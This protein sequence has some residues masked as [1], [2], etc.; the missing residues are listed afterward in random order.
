MAISGFRFASALTLSLVFLFETGLEAKVCVQIRETPNCLTEVDELIGKTEEEVRLGDKIPL[1]LIHGWNSN[2]IPAPPQTEIW[3]NLINDFL[4]D[5]LINAKVKLYIFEYYSNSGT[6]IELGRAFRDLI[7]IQSGKDPLGFGARPILIVAHSL[8]G[9]IA[10]YFLRL[11]QSEGVFENS[12]GGDRTVLLI[13]LGTPHHGTMLANGESLRAKVSE[14]W[15]STLRL[16]YAL[17]CFAYCPDWFQPNRSDLR[18]DNFDGALDY[19][20]Y[21]GERN[22]FL[23]SLNKDVDFDEKMILYGGAIGCGGREEYPEVYCAGS[24]VI[25]GVF[26]QSSDGMAPLSSAFHDGTDAVFYPEKRFTR[27]Y[28]SEYDHNQIATG[29]GDGVLFQQIKED[30]LWVLRFISREPPTGLR[31]VVGASTVSLAWNSRNPGYTISYILEI[32]SGTGRTDVLRIPVDMGYDEN[33]LVRIKNIAPGRYFARAREVLGNWAGIASNEIAFTVKGRRPKAT[34][35]CSYS[36]L[37]PIDPGGLDSFGDVLFS[38]SAR[39]IT[40]RVNASSDRCSWTAVTE[41]QWI[42]LVKGSSFGSGP[43]VFRV[44]RNQCVEFSGGSNIGSISILNSSASITVYQDSSDFSNCAG[45][46]KLVSYGM[47]R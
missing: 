12:L 47:V 43:L 35:I 11:A 15:Y 41:N 14:P 6:V 33:T 19:E 25:G 31:A 7:D 22:I 5:P 32:G 1:I 13:T 8:G 36:F 37:L 4:A 45:L 42:T 16:F 10:K 24:S 2:G 21:S 28:F 44:P 26:G 17:A 39:T 46:P 20:T 34:P 3:A 29:Q 30:I 23:E 27:R 38:S 40:L 18:W 9:L